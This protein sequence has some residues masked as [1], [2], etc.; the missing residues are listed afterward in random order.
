MAKP[1]HDVD[2]QLVPHPFEPLARRRER[3]RGRDRCLQAVPRRPDRLRSRSSR[4]SWRRRSTRTSATRRGAGRRRR[5]PGGTTTGRAASASSATA[6]ALRAE[7]RIPGADVNP[8]LAFAA[9]LAAGLYGIENELE[10]PPPLEGNAYESDAERFPHSLREAIAAL[11]K[12]TMARAASRRRRRRPLPELRPH[13]AA[14]VRP[15][16]HLLRARADV[17]AR[18]KPVIGITS[19]AEE[20]TW[21]AWSSRPR[22]SSRTPTCAG[23]S[24]RRARLLVPPCEDVIEETLAV[25]DGILFTDGSDLDPSQ[26]GTRAHPKTAGAR[27]GA[28]P[29]RARALHGGARAGHAG[30]CG[31]PRHPGARRRPRRRPDE[32]LPDSLGHQRH[33]Q[34]RAQFTDNQVKLEPESRA[35]GL[36]GER[37]P[38]SRTT[39]RATGGSA[40]ASEAGWADDGTVE[41]LE[42]P[43]ERFAVGVSGIPKRARTWPCSKR[44]SEEARGYQDARMIAVR[45][46]AT[47]ETIAEL[48]ARASRR[49]MPRSPGERG[50]PGLARRRPPWA[51]GRLLRRLGALVEEQPQELAKL[52]TRTWASHRRRARR[53]RMVAEVFDLFADAVD[54]HHWARSSWSRAASI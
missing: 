4:S 54:K 30:A 1:D 35:R 49:P 17:R 7:T 24:G 39:T 11:E 13:R 53:G 22:R 28:R 32:H 47:E 38:A 26:Y 16:R 19:Y 48:D 37:I 42:D 2:R 43:S 31:V 52:E 14:A 51:A 6:P 23:S 29:G 12:G 46:P 3:L 44:S 41:A 36:L 15:G 27:R 9:L 40:K 21:G 50:V 33:K 45:N 5:S 10:L 34:S 18:M 25:L 8:Y 20:V